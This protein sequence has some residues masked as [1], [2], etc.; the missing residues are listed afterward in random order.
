MIVSSLVNIA[1]DY[2][3]ILVFHWGVAGAAIATIISQIVSLT[4]CVVFIRRRLPHLLPTKALL[5]SLPALLRDE[6][7]AHLGLGISI[8][9]QR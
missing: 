4:C 8:G 7:A 6:G 3:F 1:L 9:L 5:R 2:T